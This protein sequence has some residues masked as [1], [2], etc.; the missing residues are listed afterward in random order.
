VQ[1]NLHRQVPFTKAAPA[2]AEIVQLSGIRTDHF[3]CM[4]RHFGGWSRLPDAVSGRSPM[5]PVL[6]LKIA[7]TMMAGW[8]AASSPAPIPAEGIAMMMDAHAAAPV[9]VALHDANLQVTERVLLY[10]DGSGE[11]ETL[12]R[13]TK[14]FRCRTTGHQKPMAQRTLAIL[15]DLAERYQGKT[16]DFVSAHRASA[17][18]SWTSP[19]RAS[20]ALDFR[21]QGVDLRE[22]RD[23][24]WRK[25]T[26]V[27]IGWYPGD[28]FVHVDSRPGK[29]DTA[30]TFVNGA[31]RYHP[32][33]AELA[34]A[35]EPPRTLQRRA[36]S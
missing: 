11:P 15:V 31:N 2:A 12:Q 13:L 14:M 36:G 20:R 8:L 25:Y 24:L 19:H 22:I 34:R 4:G 29:G 7:T 23:Y 18:E 35:K 1:A 17:G 30:W 33:W 21:I 26:E 5:V 10:R 27:G 28:G 16:I 32:Y 9:E 6:E 3:R